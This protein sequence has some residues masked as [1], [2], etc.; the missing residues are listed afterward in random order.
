MH[1]RFSADI[2]EMTGQD[3]GLYWKVTLGLFC[4]LLLAVFILGGYVDYG[5][6]SPL[7]YLVWDSEL[8]LELKAA[9]PPWAYALI[10]VISVSSLCGLPIA[11][12][13]YHFGVFDLSAYFAREQRP[14]GAERTRFIESKPSTRG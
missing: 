8:A 2:K 9:Y 7:T 10:V 14:L 4:P 5:L 13:L 1:I 6:N 12:G 11:A 3:I